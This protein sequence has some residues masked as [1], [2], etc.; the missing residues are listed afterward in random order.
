MQGQDILENEFGTGAYS[1]FIVEGMEEKDVADLKSEV[2]KIDHV[3]KVI[4][5]DSFMDLSVMKRQNIL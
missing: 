5:Y 1:L 2:E 3:K 4:W